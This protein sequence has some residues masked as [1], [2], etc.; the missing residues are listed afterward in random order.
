MRRLWRGVP[1]VPVVL[2]GGACRVNDT[3]EPT[4][5][6]SVVVTPQALQLV[7]GTAGALTAEARDGVLKVFLPKKAE[8][9]PRQIKVGVNTPGT[10]TAPVNKH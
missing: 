8:T 4:P 5:V 9:R 7:A 10:Q 3:H 2:L 1:L 6:Q